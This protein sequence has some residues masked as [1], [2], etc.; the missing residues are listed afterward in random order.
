MADPATAAFKKA[1]ISPKQAPHR[2]WGAAVGTA[3][4]VT[5]HH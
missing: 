3:G 5:L 1:E 4:E 2:V